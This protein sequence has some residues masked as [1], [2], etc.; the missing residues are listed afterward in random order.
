MGYKFMKLISFSDC[1]DEYI[2]ELFFHQLL[3]L[4]KTFSY[5]FG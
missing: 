5:T 2:I 3:Y 4:S 1:K